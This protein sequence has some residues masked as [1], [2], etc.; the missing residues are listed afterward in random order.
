VEVGRKIHSKKS[1]FANLA[2]IIFERELVKVLLLYYPELDP[3]ADDQ[4]NMPTNRCVPH[5]QR[6]IPK[7]E[8]K[9]SEEFR[10]H[11]HA[12]CDWLG[13]DFDIE[14]EV[15]RWGKISLEKGHVLRS[16]LGETMVKCPLRSARYFEAQ[17]KDREEPAFGEALAFYEI[18]EADE[19]LIVYWPLHQ[20]EQVLRQWRGI[21][22]N[23]IEVLPISA[24]KAVVGI[25]SYQQRVYVLRK[26]PGLS[27]LNAEESER[28]EEENNEGEVEVE[29]ENGEEES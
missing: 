28:S 23:D 25:W 5:Q 8:R 21:W 6:Q 24:V 2:N 4:S 3:P 13:I 14:L 22:S 16:Q 17:K 11:I 10:A 20:C 26:H 9:Y 1:P 19:L 27:L 7:K 15:R 29:G 18:I 12:I